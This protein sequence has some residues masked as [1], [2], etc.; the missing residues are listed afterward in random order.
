MYYKTEVIRQAARLLDT[1]DEENNN[2]IETYFNDKEKRIEV[3]NM[4]AN[5]E[6]MIASMRYDEEQEEATV[7]KLR[8]LTAFV[9]K[10]LPDPEFGFG[11]SL[12]PTL[13]KT[14]PGLFEKNIDI[15]RIEFIFNSE[16]EELRVVDGYDKTIQ[17][18][19]F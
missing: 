2:V 12:L 4:L 9:G 18:V 1:V 15:E 10:K 6:R 13:L 14:L 7:T 5:E 3:W 8:Q 11:G 19:K 17:V 16:T